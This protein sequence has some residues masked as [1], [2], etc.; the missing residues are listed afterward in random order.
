MC[1]I[2]AMYFLWACSSFWPLEVC[3]HVY[4]H[5]HTYT[6]KTCIYIHAYMLLPSVGVVCMKL[7]QLA[8]VSAGAM[9]ETIMVLLSALL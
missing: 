4:I 3:R 2:S 5:L 6:Y 8:L 1:L 7:A 9:L